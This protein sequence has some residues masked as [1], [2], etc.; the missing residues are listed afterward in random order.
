[1]SENL[2]CEAK[3]F[4]PCPECTHYQKTD[5]KVTKDGFYTTK[6]DKQPRQRFYCHGGKHRFSETRYSELFG[7]GG[8]FKEYEQVAKLSSYGL[9]GEAMADVLNHDPRTIDKWLFAIWKKVSNFTYL[10][11]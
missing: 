5:N 10:Y 3:L 8:S 6:N 1:M 7:L 4:C 11:A 2:K 9:G